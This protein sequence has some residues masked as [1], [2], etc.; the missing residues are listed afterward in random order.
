MPDVKFSQLAQITTV[1]PADYIP[2]VDVSDPLMS[3]NGSN[4]IISIG[5]L[6][7]SFFDGL[8]DGSIS[9]AKLQSNPNF[10]GNVT[11][12]TTTT[13][14]AVSPTEI[15]FLSGLRSNIQY[16]LDNISPLLDA[17][18][19]ITGTFDS[20]RISNASVIGK[21]LTG[22]TTGTTAAT[23][24]ATDTILQAFQKIN[25]NVNLRAPLASPTFTGTVTLP[26]DTVTSGMIADGTIV[27]ANINGNAAI[28]G[29]KINPAFATGNI[30]TTTGSLT[31]G[32]TTQ[33]VSRIGTTAVTPQV[34][35]IAT[36]SDNAGALFGRFSA[37]GAGAR[38]SFIKSRAT[39]KGD[40]TI[41]R[42]GDALGMI[43]AGGSDGTKIV[44]ATRIE[45][46]VDVPPAVSGGSFVI[47]NRY[48]IVSLGNTA[49]ASV[50]WV[51]VPPATT[52]AVGD[53][54]TATATGSA[55]TGTATEE[56]K[57]DVM[58]GR[59]IFNTTG[60]GAD[61][62]TERM[63]INSAGNVGINT[64]TIDPSCLLQLT[65]TAKGFRPPAMTTTNRAA[66]AT[67]IAG[68]MIYNT[69][70]NKLNFYNGTA[71][72]VVTSAVG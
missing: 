30:T 70:T 47:G 64:T 42:A 19:I 9:T 18:T 41:V 36:G 33:F 29:S 43:V 20:A 13:I 26:L 71:W 63:R 66:I 31:V 72:E 51:A 12:P 5:D 37:D 62:V 57:L 38:H 3:E 69:T 28:A 8:V 39:T 24:E 46:E 55:S 16:Q 10:T 35:I 7:S 61:T 54:F 17:A 27:N 21:T 1:Q 45:S 4:A 53:F 67:P 25:G 40:H 52:A 34:Q 15:S 6:T 14:G 49:W 68:L 2:I 48:R 50:G 59:L 60:R 23:V 32:D 58:P 22:F 44:E 11:L 65:S 56:P